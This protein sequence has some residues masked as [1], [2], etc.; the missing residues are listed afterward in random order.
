MKTPIINW[1]TKSKKKREE[2]RTIYKEWMINK[3]Y[4]SYGGGTDQIVDIIFYECRA[5]YIVIDV[6]TGV[7]REH[8][9]HVSEHKVF[10]IDVLNKEG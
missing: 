10:S 9:T 1:K 6:E 8:S 4:I 3:L 7:L 5:D 2:N